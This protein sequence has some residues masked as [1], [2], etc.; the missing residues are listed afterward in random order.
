MALLWPAS[1]QT[2]GIEVHGHWTITLRDQDGRV[3]REYQVENALTSDGARLLAG[4]LGPNSLV[5]G[6]WLVQLDAANSPCLGG[7]RLAEP[8]LP[9]GVLLLVDANVDTVKLSGRVVATQNGDITGVSTHQGC[10]GPAS[11]NF[12]QFSG[13]TLASP[14][15]VV[16]GQTMD[17]TVVFSFS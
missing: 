4:A 1:T 3:T 17:V 8:G 16:A 2:A 11:F 15:P 9:G 7:C 5:R 6:I 10:C 13:R 12:T 14:I